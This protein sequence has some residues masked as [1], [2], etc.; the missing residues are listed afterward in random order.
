MAR[1]FLSIKWKFLFIGIILVFIPTFILGLVIYQT[2][3]DEAIATARRDLR[4]IAAGWY[5]AADIYAEEIRRILKREEYLVEKRLGSIVLDVKKMVLMELESSSVRDEAAMLTMISRIRIGRSGYVFI[6]DDE[7]R[8]I[9]SGGRADDGKKMEEM[10]FRDKALEA[11]STMS[12]ARRLKD[13][14]VTTVH[15]DWAEPGSRELRSKMAVLAYVPERR[16]IIGAGI[17]DADFKSYDMERIVQDELK[18]RM[19]RQKIGEHG[20]IWVLN[21]AGSYVVSKDRFR[22]GE[23]IIAARD[24]HGKLFILQMIQLARELIPAGH[25]VYEYPWKN[26]G[27]LRPTRKMSAVMYYSKWDWI[28]GASAYEQDYLK[29]LATI[30][31]RVLQTCSLFL[32]IGSLAAYIFALWISR[33]IRQ[34]EEVAAS[35]NLNAVIDQKILN[36]SDEIGSLARAFMEMMRHLNDK[37]NE[38]EKSRMAL[39]RIN[40]DLENAHG[41]LVQA[42]KLAAIGQL[43]AGVAHEVNNPL[44]YVMSNLGT[45]ELYVKTYEDILDGYDAIFCREA[46]AGGRAYV[47]DRAQEAR[48]LRE[49]RKLGD[50]RRDMEALLAELHDGLERVKRI[51]IDLRTFARSEADVKVEVDIRQIIEKAITIAGNEIKYKAR[52][53][54]EYGDLPLISGFPQRLGQVF[55]NIIV[56]AAQAV[57]PGE[58]LVRIRTF[59]DGAFVVTEIVDNGCGILPENMDRIFEPFFTTKPVGQG[60]G[61]GLSVSYEIVK[62][63]QGEIRV[64]SVP[65]KG[66]TITVRLPINRGPLGEGADVAG[67]V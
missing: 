67:I 7:G 44:A 24:D 58:G 65:G 9:L 31:W 17:F 40:K 50:V 54:K 22:D 26:I 57:T 59:M 10:P 53:E 46:D 2:Y 15:Y 38:L 64:S 19:A 29:G 13:D 35:G 11:L 28:I 36:G 60:T 51:V 20:Y 14:E 5:T 1:I 56:N 34:L 4:L 62:N 37:L 27:E 48:R 8:F 25:F 39:L 43:A 18:D 41:R 61:L 55:M 45:L 52:L 63:H 47:C 33:P 30:K 42:E 49:D 66:T 23:N 3:R 16:W 32:V 21:S 12:A 6:I